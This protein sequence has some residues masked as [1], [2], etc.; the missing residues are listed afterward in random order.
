MIFQAAELNIHMV[1][2]KGVYL[3]SEAKE[4]EFGGVHD[5]LVRDSYACGITLGQVRHRL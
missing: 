3:F 4:H 2:S 5:F 1:I